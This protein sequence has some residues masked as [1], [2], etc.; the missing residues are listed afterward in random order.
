TH[1][2]ATVVSIALA[3]R[4]PA[5]QQ[6]PALVANTQ[7]ATPITRGATVQ[8]FH[9]ASSILSEKRLIHL[10]LPESFAKSAPE[11]RYPV[12]IV[13]DGEDNVPS[14]AAAASELARNGQI[15]EL[16]IVAIPNVEGAT[17]EESAE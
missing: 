17:F 4:P 16:L 1:L 9:I 8:S 14:V 6:Q 13:L 2:V 10:V 15:P 3:P 7:P 11:R 12:A 5:Q